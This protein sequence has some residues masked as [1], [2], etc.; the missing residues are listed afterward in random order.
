MK[1]TA[2][3][4]LLSVSFCSVGSITA[5]PQESV[6]ESDRERVTDTD[7]KRER[8]GERQAR[9]KQ[10]RERKD[11]RNQRGL[12]VKDPDGFAKTQD[13]QVFSGPQPGEK[14]PALK[15]TGVHGDLDGKEFDAVELADGKPQV[16][17][18]MA[19]D[20]VG[21]RGLIG[22]TKFTSLVAKKSKGGLHVSSVFLGDE[23][24]P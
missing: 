2:I 15:A 23:P 4:L 22:L 3:A 1:R 24:S 7:K 20:K 10:T 8:G 21:V 13:K 9:E 17:I 19:A 12:E 14:L 18:F 6:K 11:Y 5:I 16:L